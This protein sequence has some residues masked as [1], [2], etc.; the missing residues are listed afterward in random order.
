MAF[1]S[2]NWSCWF[3]GAGHRLHR[4]PALAP[5]DSR[6]HHS[7]PRHRRLHERGAVQT[8]GVRPGST[9]RGAARA[10]AHLG[11]PHPAACSRAR[12]VTVQSRNHFAE[13]PVASAVHLPVER[14]GRS[15]HPGFRRCSPCSGKFSAG[16]HRRHEIIYAAQ[17]LEHAARRNSAQPLP[18]RKF[19]I[20]RSLAE[21]PD[22]VVANV[23]ADGPAGHGPDPLLT[24]GQPADVTAL[25]CRCMP[26]QFKNL[27]AT[28]GIRVGA[29]SPTP[30][31]AALA[32]ASPQSHLEQRLRLPRQF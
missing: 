31:A 30:P 10:V 6:C 1:R 24:G 23:I 25:I 16:F 9:P 12:T 32:T 14:P 19:S 22:V 29:T 5:A 2:G 20:E 7:K 4:H 11:R 27:L 13:Q 8:Q 21:A 28:H 18:P 3:C 15:R 26:A 17:S